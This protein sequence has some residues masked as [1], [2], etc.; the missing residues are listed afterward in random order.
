MVLEEKKQTDKKYIVLTD[1]QLNNSLKTLSQPILLVQV[2][3]CSRSFNSESHIFFNFP[4]ESSMVTLTL[5][6]DPSVID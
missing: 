5:M 4:W 3:Y 2:R 6:L 1:N